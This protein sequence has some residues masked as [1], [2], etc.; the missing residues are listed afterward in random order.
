[1]IRHKD[2]RCYEAIHWI[3]ELMSLDLHATKAK[4]NQDSKRCAGPKLV[5]QQG[6]PSC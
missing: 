4:S 1:M 2:G 3:Q 5:N 6:P